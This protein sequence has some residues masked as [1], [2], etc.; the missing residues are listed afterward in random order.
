MITFCEALAREEGW[1]NPE[2]RCRRN[3]NPGNLNYEPWETSF[4]AKLETGPNARFAVFPTAALGF[5][6]MSALLTR[7]YAGLTVAQAIAKWAPSSENNTVQ[8]LA[9]VCTWT[10]YTPETVLVPL[11]LQPPE[12]GDAQ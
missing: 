2:S 6:A 7:Y 5:A 11:L 8:Y 4:G 12:A 3:L 9:N 1:L 10:Q